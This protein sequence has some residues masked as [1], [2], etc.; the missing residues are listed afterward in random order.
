M[1]ADTP[2]ALLL[3]PADAALILGVSEDRLRRMA[4]RGEIG[5]RRDS[6]F[7]RFAQADLDAYVASIAVPPAAVMATTRAKVRR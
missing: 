6:R 5:H 7:L 2:P 3:S 1:T 4:H